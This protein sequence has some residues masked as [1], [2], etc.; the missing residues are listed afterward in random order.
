MS[1]AL[2]VKLPKVRALGGS[3]KLE[4]VTARHRTPCKTCRQKIRTG[5]RVKFTMES[6]PFPE[7]LI[8]CPACARK[9]IWRAVR[10]IKVDVRAFCK[11]LP[12]SDEQPVQSQRA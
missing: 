7:T 3:W 10:L 8:F 6:Y 2:K 5:H 12:K 4:V 11:F 9:A 1:R